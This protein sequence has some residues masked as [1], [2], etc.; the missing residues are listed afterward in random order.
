MVECF[1]AIAEDSECGAVV[2]GGLRKHF[3]AGAKKRISSHTSFT[4]E[5]QGIC[6]L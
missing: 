2:L 1:D 6:W 5:V 3:C 4:P